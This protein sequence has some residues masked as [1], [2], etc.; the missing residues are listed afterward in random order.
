MA[1]VLGNL[2]IGLVC[3]WLTGLIVCSGNRI[4]SNILV[5]FLANSIISI[6]IFMLCDLSSVL[7]Y[8]GSVAAALLT[9]L[10]WF[11]FLKN[12]FYV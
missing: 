11:N 12:R 1:T 7:V 6:L 5:L 10:F 8:L 9:Y 2:G 4:I 3:G